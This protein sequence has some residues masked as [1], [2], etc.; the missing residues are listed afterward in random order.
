[1]WHKYFRLAGVVAV[2]VVGCQAKLHKQMDTFEQK[3]LSV[4]GFE[5]LSLEANFDRKRVLHIYIEGDGQ[6][7]IN[8]KIAMDPGPF[9][10]IALSLMKKDSAA[11]LYLGRPC[12]FQ[13]LT[14]QQDKCRPSLWSRARYSQ[15]IVDLMV[16]A[17]LSH[18]D[19]AGFEEWVLI[20]HSGGGTLAYLM[21]QHLPKVE[22]VVAV[23]SN[24]DVS[25]WVDY[26]GYAPLDQSLDPARMLSGKPLQLFYLTGGQDTNVPFQ[27]NQD[28]LRA[29]NARIIRREKYN[30]LCCWEQ[31]WSA[32]LQQLINE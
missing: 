12:Y 31:E 17:L 21:A 3:I 1:M 32:I 7:W 25:A 23:S 29:N 15:Q 27:L 22:K 16:N 2:L 11:S 14:R 4:G 24:L 28:F 10:L 19:L 5:L 26:H 18:P 20:G 8:D 6:P 13:S 30:H 9:N